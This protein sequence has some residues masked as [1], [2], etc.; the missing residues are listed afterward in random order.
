MISQTLR[1][2][3]QWLKLNLGK[4]HL[5]QNLELDDITGQIIGT[6]SFLTH[7]DFPS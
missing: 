5:F 7:F 1:F 4:I 6:N 2:Q 3:N